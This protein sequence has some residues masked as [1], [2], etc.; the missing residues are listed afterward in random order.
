MVHLKIDLVA[1]ADFYVA[2][3]AAAAAC[4]CKLV[5]AIESISI[6]SK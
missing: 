2:A 1:I 5:V 6:L 4:Y 3:A